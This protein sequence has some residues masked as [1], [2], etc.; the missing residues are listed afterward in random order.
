MEKELN[1]ETIKSAMEEAGLNQSALAEVLEVTRE[2][3]SQWLNKKT[4]P[5]PGKLLKLGK[6]LGLPFSELVVK[7]QSQ[8]PQIAFRK[9]AGTKTKDHHIEKA[10][11]MGLMLRHLVDYLPFDT[12]SLPPV[13]K[14]PNCDYEYL[15]EVVMKVRDEIRVDETGFID[16][17]HLIRRFRELQAVVI[18]VLWGTRAGHANAAHIYLPDSKTTWVYLNL[19]VNVHDFNFWMAHELGHCLSPSLRGNEAEDFADAFAGSLLYPKRLAETGYEQLIKTRSKKEQLE[20]IM[21]I[22]EEVMI[23]PYHVYLQI[24]A[25]ALHEGKTL[26]SLEPSIHKWTMN[27]N[28]GYPNLS[29]VLFKSIEPP[30]TIE[31]IEKAAAAFETPF[32]DVLRNY[33]REHHKGSG[34]VQSIMD[35]P[36]LDARSL[37]SEL[38]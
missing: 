19:E 34:M 37:H 24:N 23:S 13:L 10:Q 31:Y 27:F 8:M 30:T 17:S 35:I 33:L 11:S 4:F 7:N 18:P 22:A 29:E 25:Y 26:L 9:R 36:L 15:Q 38:T 1:I 20:S 14:N 2:T 16:F 5:R 12:L 21:R 28:R 32:F 6:L 3:A